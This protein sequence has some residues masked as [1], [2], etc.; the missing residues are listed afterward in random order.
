MLLAESSFLKLGGQAQMIMENTWV[1]PIKALVGTS[2]FSA[3]FAQLI[4]VP[5]LGDDSAAR[6][7]FPDSRGYSGANVRWNSR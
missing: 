5:T 6:L 7:G 1:V 2:I 4:R 3:F